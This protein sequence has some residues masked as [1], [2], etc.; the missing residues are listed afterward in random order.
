MMPLVVAR[1]KWL[2]RKNPGYGEDI[3]ER[4][5]H[6]PKRDDQPLWIHAVSVGETIASE[7]LVKLIQET[8]PDWP[9]LITNTTPTGAQ[10]AKRLF[11][12][13]VTRHFAPYDTPK[14][15]HQ[16]LDNARPR[17]LVVME[18]ELWPNW[19]SVLSRKN[20]PVLVANARLS[21]KSAA[22]YAR[23]GGMAK[24][25]MASITR[26]AAQYDADAQRFLQLGSAKESVFVSG[27]IKADIEITE[28]D[29]Q[30][31]QDEKNKIS[32][33][34]TPILIAAS[35]HPGEDEIVLDSFVQLRKEYPKALL[36]LVPRHP[37]RADDVE[38]LLNQRSLGFIKRTT[39]KSDVT[40]DDTVIL[41]DK[42]G[43][44]RALFGVA[45][46][47]IMGGTF[48]DHGGHNPL[49]PAAWG[50]PIVA[51]P[52]QRNFDSLFNEMESF[53][54]LVRSERTAEALSQTLV[55]LLG[56]GQRMQKTGAAALAYIQNQRGAVDRLLAAIESL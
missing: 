49:E 2:S 47:A 54:A 51:G 9:I 50:M 52:S 13:S 15:I 22:G 16:F 6:I 55:D 42:M 35:T 29:R 33:Q 31:A 10:Q 7:P 4:F 8:H 41:C 21:E 28:T 30:L 12:E 48:V 1:L 20:I 38:L 18:T 53:E 56:D 26:V 19:I 43:E 39:N 14:A 5:G 24:E 37:E 11:G 36:Y 34:R 40:P 44:L 23:L 45:D 25:M 32:S 27:N 46:I 3:R 17:A